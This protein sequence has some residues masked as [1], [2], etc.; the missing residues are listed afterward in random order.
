MRDPTKNW[1]ILVIFFGVILL[2]RLDIK[3]FS[4]FFNKERQFLYSL[5]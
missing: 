5:K 4:T 1:P 3:M 2:K